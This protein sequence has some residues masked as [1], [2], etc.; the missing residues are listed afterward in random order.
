MAPADAYLAAGL[1]V[2]G[3]LASLTLGRKPQITHEM[4]TGTG[5]VLDRRPRSAADGGHAGSRVGAF[6]REQGED[7]P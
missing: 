4:I 6:T 7:A 1:T 2:L 3:S 5:A